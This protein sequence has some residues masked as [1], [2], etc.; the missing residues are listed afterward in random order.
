MSIMVFAFTSKAGTLSQFSLKACFLMEK[1]DL[2]F[3][4]PSPPK[5]NHAFGRR[6][7]VK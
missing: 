3:P 6:G 2:G 7:D 4:P 5:K 1:N